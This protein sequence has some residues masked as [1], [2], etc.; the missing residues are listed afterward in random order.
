MLN[1]HVMVRKLFF[2]WLGLLLPFW[3]GLFQ[4][5]RPRID[6]PQPG[7]ALQGLVNI[8]GMTDVAGFRKMEAAFS[9]GAGGDGT[10]F[11]IGQ[12][13]QPVRDGTLAT[14]DT[15]TIADGIY[16]LRIRVETED[17]EVVEVLV[18]DLR[19]RNYTPV[20]T[21]TPPPEELTAQPEIV[22]PVST[23]IPTPTSL[24]PN[25]ASVTMPRLAFSIVQG[26]VFV[27]VIFMIIGIYGASRWKRPRR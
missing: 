2:L 25:P 22:L 4:F 18:K 26:V 3:S 17:D 13:D 15:S 21:N 23:V 19:V 20:E 14:W 1:L 6:S 16:Q 27:F 10:W 24:P 12:S 9:Y 11:L 5:S 7:E 8:T